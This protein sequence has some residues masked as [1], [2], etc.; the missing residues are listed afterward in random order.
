M[1][2][3]VGASAE[4]GAVSSKILDFSSAATSGG[5]AT[6]WADLAAATDPRVF[7]RCW[8]PITAR[9]FPAIRQAAILMEPGSGISPVPMARWAAQPAESSPEA[10]TEGCARSYNA[11]LAEKRSVI[12]RNDDALSY[13]TH[14]FLI[15]GD[16]RGAVLVEAKLS[17]A[18][19][20]TR[21][22]RHL[23]WSSAWVEA[24]IRRSEAHSVAHLSHRA[25]S[26]GDVVN[27]VLS[28]E[29]Y[30]PAARALIEFLAQRLDCPRTAIGHRRH[31]KTEILAL[32]QT[33]AT[34]QRSEISRAIA[35][36]M[37]EALDQEAILLAPAD[38][39]PT[40]LIAHAQQA[41]LS[42]TRAGAVLTLPMFDSGKAFGAV[43]LMRDERAFST[44]DLD[45]A[46]ALV[47]A[48][49][50]ALIEKHRADR[51]PLELLWRWA[52]RPAVRLLGKD[53]LAAKIGI[54]TL[55]VAASAGWFAHG[56][57]T[58]VAHGQVHG[59][60]R[61]IVGAPFDGY[62][63]TQ[64]ARAGEI[65]RA[66]DLLAELQDNDLVLQRLRQIAQR[67]QYQLEHD[68]A[69][70][71]HDLAQINIAQAQFEQAS[72][73][74]ELS[75]QMLQRAQIRAPFDAVVVSGDLSQSIGKPVSRG[76]TLFELA[77]LDRYR[78][79]LVVPESDIGAI[80]A[81][82]EGQLLL[83]ALPEEPFP[84]SIISVTPVARV[85]DG[86]NG[87]EA[88]ASLKSAD[89]RIRPSMEGAA[90][91]DA[92]EAKLIWIWTHSLTQWLRVKLWPWLP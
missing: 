57:Y 46:D 4:L 58:V 69:L 26:I 18:L 9:T 60:I 78:L 43:T 72:A 55:L 76:D 7:S 61:R 87:F 6:V 11:A 8:L 66:G 45:F 54:A 84:I 49:T 44:S 82:A 70:A 85:A 73:E 10:F 68:R 5:D 52:R 74:I 25:S 33:A 32:S 14:P 23:Q 36:A 27:A 77:P 3:G 59:E 80:K 28:A 38:S 22:L 90:K 35:D 86:V 31:L 19:S 91:I 53:H 2:T 17:D 1:R 71:K 64:Q 92:G 41:L 62:L 34:D 79:T 21:L 83:T 47:A 20:G 50:P 37:D 51:G 24:F 67:Q 40:S 29:G 48:A 39:A 12:E 16:V 65:V 88:L 63:K 81:G 56:R 15:D 13:A 89:P 30:L 75:D 42:T